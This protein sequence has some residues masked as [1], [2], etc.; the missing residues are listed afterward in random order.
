MPREGGGWAG[1]PQAEGADLAGPKG[2]GGAVTSDLS[3]P[4]THRFLQEGAV[5]G[6]TKALEPMDCL[7]TPPSPLY[8]AWPVGH[9]KPRQERGPTLLNQEA[10]RAGWGEGS[11]SV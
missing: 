7:L 5:T 6:R 11:S 3:T 2:S 10:P 9:C 4:F 8:W 1:Q